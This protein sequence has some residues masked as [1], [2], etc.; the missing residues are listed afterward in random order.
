MLDFLAPKTKVLAFNIRQVPIQTFEMLGIGQINPHYELDYQK[1][2]PV[3]IVALAHFDRKCDEKEGMILSDIFTL[4][5]CP[6]CKKVE[7]YPT[8]MRLNFSRQYLQDEE[9]YDL[10]EVYNS[11]YLFPSVVNA[12]C[13]HCNTCFEIHIKRND[14]WVKEAKKIKEK[15]LIS[16][17]WEE[18]NL[19]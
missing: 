18:Y 4:R 8:K 14:T 10:R 1:E 17:C 11:K 13:S 12:F 9:D 5:R 3:T 7:L 15:D 2:I 6:K 19:D 16:S